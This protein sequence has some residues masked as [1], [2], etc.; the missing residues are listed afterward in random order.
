MC[1]S[2]SPT[3]TTDLDLNS[4]TAFGTQLLA[5]KWYLRTSFSRNPGLDLS[6]SPNTKGGCSPGKRIQ[7]GALRAKGL[8]LIYPSSS[9][10]R[11]AQSR[12]HRSGCKWE[13][14]LGISG[15][16]CQ[17]KKDVYES[18][19]IC[20]G[21]GCIISLWIHLGDGNHMVP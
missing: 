4:I 11:K 13:S 21:N 17:F 9:Q 12:E 19:Q 1:L 15:F 14:G 5:K 18:L 8:I 16:L 2:C 7:Q 3:Q 20:R 10:Y 6:S